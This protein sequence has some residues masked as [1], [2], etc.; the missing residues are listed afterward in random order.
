MLC[1]PSPKSHSSRS[2]AGPRPGGMWHRP[3]IFW[4]W[5]WHYISLSS[6]SE[7]RI[8]PWGGKVFLLSEAD[9]GLLDLKGITVSHGGAPASVH[10]RLTRREVWSEGKCGEKSMLDS[11]EWLPC[12]VLDSGH[13]WLSIPHCEGPLC[14]C[15]WGSGRVCWTH[16]K[17][18][19]FP[20]LMIEL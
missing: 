13:R 6:L 19:C 5:S 7:P 8:K 12:S 10:I 2:R 11:V 15:G 9:Q 3:R 20:L 16:I 4:S 14:V 1:T 18:A 17:T